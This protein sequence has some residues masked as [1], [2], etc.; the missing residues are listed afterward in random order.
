MSRS[1]VMP[2][3]LRC[4]RTERPPRGRPSSPD[5]R[6]GVGSGPCPPGCRGSRRSRS[7]LPGVM[8]QDE[9][10]SLLRLEAPE[11]AVELVAV[12]DA[13]QVVGR[14]RPSTGSTEGG[15]TG[16][17]RATPGVGSHRSRGVWP[18]VEAVRIADAPQVA[19]GDHQCVLQ[20][21]LSPIDVAEDP[22]GDPNS[23]SLRMR[24]R[25]AYASR[26]PPCA[27]SIRSRSTRLSLLAGTQRGRRPTLL[28]VSAACNVHS[29][30]PVANGTA[31][32]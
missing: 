31:V 20:G 23:R 32:P 12:G 4:V 22:L 5:G 11:S 28:V 8:V 21:I 15:A 17:G 18:G 1:C 24:T 19:P 3:V 13:E 30:I 16:G 9:K 29:S 14:R 25:S 10:G 27:A 26:S 2:D 6:G 7:A